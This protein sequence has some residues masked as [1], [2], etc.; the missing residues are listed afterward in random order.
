MREIRR[1]CHGDQAEADISMCLLSKQRGQYRRNVQW[2]GRHGVAHTVQLAQSSILVEF[3]GLDT[4]PI[5]FDRAVPSR[6]V[7]GD[8]DLGRSG[9]E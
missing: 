3:R 9:V 2:H 4:I 6:E 8:V 1:L 5:I 7:D